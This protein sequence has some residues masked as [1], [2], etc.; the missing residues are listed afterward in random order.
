MR[1][2]RGAR[3]VEEGD[4]R[5]PPIVAT[6]GV[7]HSPTNKSHRAGASTFSDTDIHPDVQP[8]NPARP[9]ISIRSANPHRG[10]RGLA[11]LGVLISVE[12]AP[13]EQRKVLLTVGAASPV[14]V[15]LHLARH[16]DCMNDETREVG[17]HLLHL[18]D[19]ERGHRPADRAECTLSG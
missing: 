18:A 4:G 10:G 19:L 16:V 6:F 5:C 11:C 14:P 3:G 7:P 1:D 13:V 12:V 17:E 9:G 15:L 8:S 2:A